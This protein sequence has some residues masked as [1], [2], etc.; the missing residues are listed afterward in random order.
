VVH[1]A[2]G[3]DRLLFY[4]N[5]LVPFF[6]PLRAGADK[7]VTIQEKRTEFIPIKE[8][9][10]KRSPNGFSQQQPSTKTKIR[11]K[12]RFG[13]KI[14]RELALP[15][16]NTICLRIYLAILCFLYTALKLMWT[17]SG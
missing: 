8:V 3:L 15:G 13:R 2:H 16:Y 4:V 6:L 11:S 5:F 17:Q 7:N 9:I 12:L 1:I 14:S 10:L